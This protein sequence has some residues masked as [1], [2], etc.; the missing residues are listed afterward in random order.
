[1]VPHHRR[2]GV[3]TTKTHLGANVSRRHSIAFYNAAFLLGQSRMP[4]VNAVLLG[5]LLFRS[6]LVPRVLPA[7]LAALPVA[8]WEFSVAARRFRELPDRAPSERAQ[9]R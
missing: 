6:R 1:M 8:L 5:T 3:S 4:A 2:S 9:A 7:L